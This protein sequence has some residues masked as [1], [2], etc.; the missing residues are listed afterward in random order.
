MTTHLAPEKRTGIQILISWANQQDHWVR[1][2]TTEVLATRADLSDASVQSAYSLLQA[3]K[4]LN[5]TTAPNVPPLAEGLIPFADSDPLHLHRISDVAGVNALASGQAILFNPRLTVLF[6]E[7]AAGKTGYVRVLK[8]LASARAA[9]PIL[10]NVHAAPTCTPRATIEYSLSG[11]A[12]TLAWNAESG[13][14]P[15]TRISVFDSTV[16]SLH[17]DEDLTYVFTPAELALFLYVHRAIDAVKRHLEQAKNNSQPK[18][19]NPFLHRF[20]PDS[21]IYPKI[22]AIGHTTSL[23][24]LRQFATVTAEEEA[25]IATLRTEIESLKQPTAD[26]LQ[27]ATADRDLYSTLL[28]AAQLTNSFPW[29]TY[30]AALQHLRDVH[31]RHITASHN[32]F[33][34][35]NIPALFSAA[36]KDFIIA[37]ELYLRKSAA[38]LPLRVGDPCPY[39]QQNLTTKALTLVLKYRDYCSNELRTQL[40]SATDVVKQLIEPLT[41]LQLV[42]LKDSCERRRL[43][44]TDPSCEPPLLAGALAFIALLTE[45]LA[46]VTDEKAVTDIDA[47]RATANGLISGLD[48]AITKLTRSIS[49]LQQQAVQRAQQV[50]ALSTKLRVIENRLTLRSLLPDL[51]TYVENAKWAARATP[52]VTRL[53]SLLRELTEHSKAA[54]KEMLDNDFERLFYSEC[55]LLLAPKVKLGF[56]GRKGQVCVSKIIEAKSAV[57]ERDRSGDQENSPRRA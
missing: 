52:I 22:E 30:N 2:I 46:Q 54:S 38:P 27:V 7:N 17:V 13:L 34:D 3:E 9:Q 11:T 23:I 28:T 40:D 44:Y 12:H 47:T 42:Y 6:G 32:S 10:G 36:W 8:R 16:V 51:T 20:T 37:G 14:S 35:E 5:S 18:P 55:E 48:D 45:R 57:P 31:A 15:F 39:C 21:H 4:G 19:V 53:T 43:T 25:E 50:E 26:R 49:D 33:S 29:E 24:D 1:A 41:A 56:A